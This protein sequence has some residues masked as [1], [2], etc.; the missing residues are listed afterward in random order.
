VKVIV[1]WI[2]A[3]LLVGGANRHPLLVQSA[4]FLGQLAKPGI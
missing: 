4:S 1:R 3:P 2:L